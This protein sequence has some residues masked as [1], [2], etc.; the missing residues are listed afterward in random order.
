MQL[1]AG[2]TVRSMQ[3]MSAGLLPSV[4]VNFSPLK[5]TAF[6]L[7]D[8]GHFSHMSAINLEQVQAA[9]AHLSALSMALDFMVE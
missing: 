2:S 4:A 1:A 5:L 3:L 8:L 7:M 6:L 9:S